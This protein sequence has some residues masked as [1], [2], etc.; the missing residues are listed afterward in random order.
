MPRS[1]HLTARGKPL[2]M[3]ERFAGWATAMAGR[4]GAFALALM[5]VVI[6]GLTGPLFSFSEVWQ[7]VINTG[8]TIV[9]FLMVFLIQH[10]QNKDS[11]A[12]HL[13][14][15]ELI[16]SHQEASNRMVKI[17]DLSD[18]ELEVL[19]KFYGR[20]AQLAAKENGVKTTHSLDEADQRHAHKHGKR[21]A[22]RR[23]PARESAHS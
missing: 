9:T 5:T 15:N 3:F 11:V 16:A 7:L 2:S 19:Q 22:Q 17:E 1:R 20:L 12:L 21:G 6:W 8:T 18:D 14:L 4:S 10:Q 13:K 23:A